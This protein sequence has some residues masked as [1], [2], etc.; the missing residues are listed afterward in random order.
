MFN[1]LKSFSIA[2]LFIPFF[3]HAEVIKLK[4]TA[5]TV[6][7]VKTGDTLWDISN[8]FLSKPWYWP[9]IWRT[10]T[11]IINPHLIFPGDEL[12]LTK[13]VAGEP[14]IDLVRSQQKPYIVRSPTAKQVPKYNQP[15]AVLPWHKITPYF[16][17]EKVL[18]K[19]EYAALPSIIGSTEG[20]EY[21]ANGDLVLVNKE[22]MT[23]G[24]YEVVRKQQTL[25]NQEGDFLAIAIRHIADGQALVSSIPKQS[26]VLLS[27]ANL[28]VKRGDKLLKVSEVNDTHPIVQ[29]KAATDQKAQIIA[30]LSQYQLSSKYSVVIIDIGNNDIDAGIVMG[31][32]QQG[33]AVLDSEPAQYLSE[34]QTLERAF[35]FNDVLPQ[36]W[37]KV[38]E[39]LVFKV[40]SKVSYAL[41]TRSSTV[42]RKGAIVAKP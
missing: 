42:I 9:E 33:A 32:Y 25:Y 6:Y 41:V 31:I 5:P 12:R 26:L 11:Q 16:N 22:S 1:N 27:A 38:G 17:H 10:N 40:F 39:L 2:L 4:D 34:S 19:Q 7:I 15:I 24:H 14:I 35:S 3:L 18:S 30:D 29:I 28:E 20:S 37:M 21:F 13:N 36:P 23:S 8:L